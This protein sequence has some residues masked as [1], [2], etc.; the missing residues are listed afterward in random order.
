MY[1]YVQAINPGAKAH[2]SGVTGKEGVGKRDRKRDKRALQ[3]RLPQVETLQ[4]Q[5][6][7]SSRLGPEAV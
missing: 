1:C 7:L 2:N 5:V 6:P 4:G 3:H